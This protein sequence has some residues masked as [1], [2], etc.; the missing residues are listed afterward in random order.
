[1]K[2]SSKSKGPT[3]LRVCKN[4]LNYPLVR[5]DQRRLQISKIRKKADK[6]EIKDKEGN[7]IYSLGY[8]TSPISENEEF[9]FS[10]LPSLYE[11]KILWG[12]LPLVQDS[13]NKAKKNKEPNWESNLDLLTVHFPSVFAL[14][15]HLKLP[16]NN[17]KYYKE[18]W[19]SLQRLFRLE[20]EYYG[21][22]YDPVSKKR[23]S[24]VFHLINT[25]KRNGN[26][27]V[28]EFN[29]EWVDTHE[30]YYSHIDLECIT[31]IQSSSIL[32]TF[33]YFEAW[34]TS[35]KTVRLTRNLDGL[36]SCLGIE[37]GSY[38]N[39]QK[40]EA[41]VESIN[42]KIPKKNYQ[43]N[44]KGKNVEIVFLEKEGELV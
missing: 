2:Q 15:K 22:W 31:K 17:S 6:V 20:V 43:I 10:Y 24:K 4:F 16:T 1:M 37:A 32:N 30:K 29:R 28:I 35:G 34:K 11:M 13:R 39:R 33:L 7:L 19:P 36:C 23:Q 14:L 41:I 9:I 38:S 40:F 18:F 42:K 3:S 12:L 5:P 27:V 21:V 25:I 8:G 44:K 26:E